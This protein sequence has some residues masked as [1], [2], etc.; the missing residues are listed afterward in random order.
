MVSSI[1]VSLSSAGAFDQERLAVSFGRGGQAQ[2]V[3]QREEQHQRI[4]GQ[5]R[6]GQPPSQKPGTSQTKPTSSS[7][8]LRGVSPKAQRRR[9]SQR[10]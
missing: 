6:E 2:A 8:M 5:H 3:E 10:R 7:P 4:P 9:R 1:S